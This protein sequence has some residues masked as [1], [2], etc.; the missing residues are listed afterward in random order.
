MHPKCV[1]Q[2]MVVGGANNSKELACSVH[3]NSESLLSIF[4][5]GK[6]SRDL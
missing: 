4:F 2:V 3:N 5:F 1:A 6:A